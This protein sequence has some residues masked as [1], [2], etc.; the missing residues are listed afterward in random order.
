MFNNVSPVLKSH[1]DAAQRESTFFNRF[2]EEHG[3]FNPFAD[4]GWRTLT[5][6]FEELVGSLRGLAILDIGCG[7]GQSRRIYMDRATQYVGVDLAERAIE[8]ARRRFPKSEWRVADACNLPFDDAAFDVVAFSSVLHHIPDFGQALVE[9]RR[10]LKPGGMVFAFDPNLLHPAMALFR[11]PASPF[12][13]SKGVSPDERPLRPSALKKAFERA[14]LKSIRQR[15]QSD[16]PY[17][18]VAPVLLNACL[19]L[20]N[21]TDWVMERTYLARWFGTFVVTSG[22]KLP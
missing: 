19:G 3:D 11:H 2:A 8:T 16:I 17:R 5:N 22:R 18:H 10:V 1:N 12:Y 9:G 14:G 7:T 4:R 21:F 13:S 20:Y 15:C 6:R